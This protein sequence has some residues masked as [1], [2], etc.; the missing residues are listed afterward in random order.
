MPKTQNKTKFFAKELPLV[1]NT[2]YVHSSSACRYAN[3][4]SNTNEIN[5]NSYAS[6]QSYTLHYC[7]SYHKQSFFIT[8]NL[9]IIT[10][11]TNKAQ[12]GCE[13]LLL[14]VRGRWEGR[15]PLRH[16]KPKNVNCKALTSEIQSS[17]KQAKFS[18][19]FWRKN[20]TIKSLIA[21]PWT[22]KKLYSFFPK[23][24]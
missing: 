6:F 1:Q 15:C 5:I 2:P 22:E 17:S 3:S 16:N 7:D 18:R 8:T 11:L 14:R 23:K 13:R 21:T 9:L 4:E 20:H 19:R 10:W 12:N 24:G